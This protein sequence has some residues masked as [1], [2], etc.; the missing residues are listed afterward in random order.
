MP[1]PFSYAT[2][3]NNLALTIRT[4]KDEIIHQYRELARREQMSFTMN[5]SDLADASYDLLENIKTYA[6]DMLE[7]V[8]NAL[9]RS[10]VHT[11]KVSSDA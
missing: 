6:P 1:A 7:D 11:A 3:E 8:Q 10:E 4:L 5:I 9:I 2:K